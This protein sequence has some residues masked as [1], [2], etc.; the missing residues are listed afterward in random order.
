MK[1]KQ[2][3]FYSYVFGRQVELLLDYLEKDPRRVIQGEAVRNLY[4][5]ADKAPHM[6]TQQNIQVRTTRYS[7]GVSMQIVTNEMTS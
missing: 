4:L 3:K 6:W 7:E 5:L 1:G 2:I